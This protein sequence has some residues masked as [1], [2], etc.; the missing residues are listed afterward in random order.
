MPGEPH[1]RGLGV[2]DHGARS[3]FLHPG[4][5]GFGFGFVGLGNCFTEERAE[6]SDPCSPID[7]R[8]AVGPEVPGP[9][10]DLTMSLANAL[11]QPR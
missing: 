1:L 11:Q 10:L 4:G 2:H 7:R 9:V 5:K 3:G 6:I 8:G